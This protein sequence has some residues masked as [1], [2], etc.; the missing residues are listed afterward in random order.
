[1]ESLKIYLY[2]T[3]LGSFPL[4]FNRWRDTSRMKMCND[5]KK[6]KIDEKRKEKKN[7]N[8]NR[9]TE[10]QETN[11]CVCVCFATII[12]IRLEIRTTRFM[13]I[14]SIELTGD[15]SW[16]TMNKMICVIGM[17]SEDVCQTCKQIFILILIERYCLKNRKSWNVA[18]II[19]RKYTHERTVRILFFKKK[20]YLRDCLNFKSF[21]YFYVKR[22]WFR[23]SKIKQ[24]QRGYILFY[25]NIFKPTIKTKSKFIPI[26]IKFL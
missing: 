9:P 8:N 6:K 5:E 15:E 11:V 18:S 19:D 23:K 14:K 24:S 7:N 3:T 10:R 2:T 12:K 17:N 25:L 22:C 1:M 13:Y 4:L 20:I 16:G 21:F 26:I